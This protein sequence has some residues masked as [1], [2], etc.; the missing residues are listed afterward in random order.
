VQHPNNTR[1]NLTRPHRLGKRLA[2]QQLESVARSLCSG[3]T[4]CSQ[5]LVLG[6]LVRSAASQEAELD[7]SAT[8]RLDE[9]L[10]A[11]GSPSP[12]S[13]DSTNEDGLRLLR[14]LQRDQLLRRQTRAQLEASPPDEL[15]SALSESMAASKLAGSKRVAFTPRIGR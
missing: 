4:E 10:M 13:F 7:G 15:I 3:P 14:M 11:A 2:G 12:S 5:L 6:A 8:G 1:S 9:P